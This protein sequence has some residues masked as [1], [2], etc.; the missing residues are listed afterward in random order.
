MSVQSAAFQIQ[1]TESHFRFPE[2]LNV[3]TIKDET[4]VPSEVFTPSEIS[5]MKEGTGRVS[6]SSQE[7]VV[8]PSLFRSVATKFALAMTGLAI[9]PSLV[10]ATSPAAP[11]PS[12][13]AVIERVITA[14]NKENEASQTIRMQ[15]VIDEVIKTAEDLKT[16]DDTPNQMLIEQKGMPP[17]A[18]QID[19]VY[20]K[21]YVGVGMF[22][23]V[24]QNRSVSGT[25]SYDAKT[26]EASMLYADVIEET[27]NGKVKRHVEFNAD[28]TSKTYRMSTGRSTFE[29]K[30][31]KAAEIDEMF[32]AYSN[33]DVKSEVNGAVR[34]LMKL[35]DT[36]NQM[37]IEQPGM[38]PV[39]VQ[40]DN[41][42]GKG[43][44]GVGMSYMITRSRAISGTMSY[45]PVT[46]K[47]SM[48]YAD[49]MQRVGM[50]KINR[51]I[52]FNDNGDS[53]TYRV[54]VRN[55]SFEVKESR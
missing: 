6:F 10:S 32:R 43:K 39:A 19:N 22:C 14:E 9:L 7:E 41:L 17:A 45:D 54:S 24:S 12:E 37:L 2:R 52:E 8:K 27:A 55:A 34:D 36:P 38:S 35:D 30:I 33:E 31:D 46:E 15:D 20:G 18:V 48:I 50:Q 16:L 23:K 28:E 29:A 51:H 13:P 47:P 11:A 21:G 1:N 44:V 26:G 40:I 3:Q 42:Q 49:V 4:S 25:M 53:A 5:E